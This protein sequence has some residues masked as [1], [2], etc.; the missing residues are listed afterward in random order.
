MLWYACGPVCREQQCCFA[1]CTLVDLDCH[2]HAALGCRGQLSDTRVLE[3]VG[4][5][6]SSSCL[7]R[8][9]GASD[10]ALLCS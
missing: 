4:A 6:S 10:P 8:M 5:R 7:P 3:A 2:H 1:C 9:E